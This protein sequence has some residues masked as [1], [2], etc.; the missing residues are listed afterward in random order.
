MHRL[1]SL[2][3]AHP[4]AALLLL[5]ALTAALGAGALRVRSESGYRAFLGAQHPV[6][7]ELE[8]ISQRFGSGVPF[9]ITYR[10]GAGAAC[11]N[12]LDA[13]GLALAYDLATKL[14]A[15]PG[16]ARVESPATSALLAPALFELPRARHLLEAG[17]P[18]NDSAEL[19]ERAFADPLWLG[20][21]VSA[22]GTMG[23]LLVQLEDAS[24]ATAERSVDAALAATLPW[25]ARGVVFAL[26]G[27]PVEFVVAGREL[28]Q[29]ANALVPVI[30]VLVGAVV[31]FALRALLPALLALVCVGVALLWTLGLQ[32]WLAI[33]RTS[34]FQ[35]LPPLMLTI[36][37]C[38]GIHLI[39]AYAERLGAIGCAQARDSAREATLLAACT[40]VSRACLYTAL[41]TAAGFA[42]FHTSGLESLVRFGWIAAFGVMAALVATFSLLPIALVRVP[43]HWIR[44]HGSGAVQGRGR[45]WSGV[46]DAIADR[47]PRWRVAILGTCFALVTLGALGMTQLRVDAS[48]EQIYGEDSRVVRWAREASVLRGGETLELALS[49]PPGVE[50]HSLGALRVL[51]RLE[52]LEALPGIGRPLSILT[53]IRQLHELTHFSPLRVDSP[54]TPVARPGELLRMLRREDA[55][56][57]RQFAAPAT[58]GEPAALRLVFQ[59][60]KLP[61]DELRALLAQ[62]DARVAAVL[63][64]GYSATVSGPLA[65]VSRMLDEIRATQI[66]SFGA[67]LALVFVLAALCFRSLPLA[68]LALVPTTLPVVLTLGAM[69]ALGVPLDIGTAMVAAI[70]LGL[71]VDESLHILSAYQ[72]LRA[73]GASR[74]RA[75]DSALREVGRALLTSAGALMVG[76]LVLVF[77]PWH[78]LASFGGVT[79]IAIAASLLADLFVLPALMLSAPR[80]GLPQR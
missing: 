49:L 7:R 36:G 5:A 17:V 2:S 71:G 56:L 59:G 80:A 19:R 70:V 30:V 55:A 9:A 74:E 20:Q 33:P 46:V 54:D 60:E 58:E 37:V 51:A 57:A 10:C 40:S 24:S 79:A 11:A 4:R 1:A 76:F 26:V 23:A 41:T 38:Y 6:V 64:P 8:A 68:L 29:Q 25:Q 31:A 72:R 62:V 67:A 16:V 32:G 18:P 34:F 27:G 52:Q 47:V 61:Q 12:A 63:P 45:G 3:L 28:E 66:G 78:S 50:A 15:I 77:V 53:P 39:S 75:I 44:P 48:F 21:L 14:A 69:G 42:S 13:D 73:E 43:A 65:V 22:D 35:V